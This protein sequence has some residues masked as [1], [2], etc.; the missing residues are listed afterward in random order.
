MFLDLG[1]EAWEDDGREVPVTGRTIK[2]TKL[3]C[4][5]AV[6]S[7]ARTLYAILRGMRI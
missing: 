7:V 1:L 3:P 5:E 2:V 6:C 4:L